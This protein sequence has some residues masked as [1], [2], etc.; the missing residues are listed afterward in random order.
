DPKGQL[1]THHENGSSSSVQP[2]CTLLTLCEGSIP[3]WPHARL[4]RRRRYV[5]RLLKASQCPR[6]ALRGSS[7]WGSSGYQ[8]I[9]YGS[10]PTTHR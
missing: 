10:S 9:P 2:S 6:T 4:E 7:P 1:Q 3:S 5:Y 8:C